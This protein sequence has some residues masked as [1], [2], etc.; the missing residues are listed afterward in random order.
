MVS[1]GEDLLRKFVRAFYP[2]ES[3]VVIEGLIRMKYIK[4]EELAQYL[5]LQTKQVRKE[6]EILRRDYVVKCDTKSEQKTTPSHSGDR[7]TVY[8]IH[9]WYIDYQHLVDVITFRYIKL[10]NELKSI[11]DRQGENT[12]YICENC[13]RTFSQLD[14]LSCT[15]V[16]KGIFYCDNCLNTL[17][18]KN[19][20][21]QESVAKVKFEE[22][23]NQFDRL[24]ILLKQAKSLN[25][26]SS[27]ELHH[28]YI[29]NHTDII[30]LAIRTNIG[31]IGTNYSV[32]QKV[33]VEIEQNN[34]SHTSGA[35]TSKPQPQAKSKP[36]VP[37]LATNKPAVVHSKPTNEHLVSKSQKV[38][39]K[40][41]N[42]YINK[43]SVTTST[44][45]TTT[46]TST[47]SPTI[48]VPRTPES[49]ASTP[50]SEAES[51]DID[52]SEMS[53]GAEDGIEGNA[54]EEEIVLMEEDYVTIGNDKIPW[55]EV[56]DTDQGRM[57][58][59]EHAAF[60]EKYSERAKFYG[61]STF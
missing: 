34:A 61:F 60:I 37:W 2:Q 13:N 26:K 32:D 15:N 11:I 51:I 40:V 46:T 44:T 36:E 48:S 58:P 27:K 49:M 38:D 55:N 17:V 50:R 10:K 39:L 33:L 18:E 28:G 57:T 22:F 56:T 45:T 47:S 3:V 35:T 19:A 25:L 6:L 8:Q 30:D 41:Y 23:N 20:T 59:K 9:S 21:D 1:I 42:E 54:E 16:E 7:Q 24:V 53:T 4:D 31:P 14:V 12:E 52:D 29:D 43:Q 5:H